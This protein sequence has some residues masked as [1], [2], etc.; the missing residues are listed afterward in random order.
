M[1]KTGWHITIIK[2]I[3]MKIEKMLSKR[4]KLLTEGQIQLRKLLRET[5]FCDASI[6]C[7]SWLKRYKI[8]ILTKLNLTLVDCT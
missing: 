7:M 5:Q 1:P 2:Q 6:L 4:A 3:K 8:I